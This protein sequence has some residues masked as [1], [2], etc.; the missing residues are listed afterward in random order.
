MRFKIKRPLESLDEFRTRINRS[1]REEDESYDPGTDSDHWLIGARLRNIGSIQKDI[2]HG[3]GAELAS[4]NNIAV[5]P[6]NGW[7]RFSTK[8]NRY[9]QQVRYSLIITIETE[10][11][12]IDL[13]TPVYNS[14]TVTV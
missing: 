3:T 1:A 13:Y 8:L 11:T 9:D 2:W 4:M 7:W 6:V 14:I 5:Y 10:E 12:Q